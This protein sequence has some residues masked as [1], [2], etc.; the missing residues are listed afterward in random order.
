MLDSPGATQMPH[1]RDLFAPLTWHALVPDQTHSVVTAGF[2]TMTT[3]G[4][5]DDSDYVTA[6]RTPDG[7]LVMAY[8]PTSRT[9]TVDMT[10]LRGAARAQFYDPS[11]GTY[12]AVAGSPLANTGK[13]YVHPARAE[14]GWRRRLGARAASAVTPTG[15]RR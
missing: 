6:A 13:P 8:M 4:H 12:A 1:V 3:T 15:S 5:V 2:G 10:Q 7:S 9:L 14:R 11:S